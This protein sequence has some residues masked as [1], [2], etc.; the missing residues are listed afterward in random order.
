MVEKEPVDKK[1]AKEAEQEQEESFPAIPD[2][3]Y[4][5]LRVSRDA[6]EAQINSAFKR[7]I[8]EFHPDKFNKQSAEKQ[9][10]ANEWTRALNEARG[11]LGNKDK[12]ETYDKAHPDMAEEKKKE[13]EKKTSEARDE[14]V[15]T[16]GMT[17]PREKGAGGENNVGRSR[18]DGPDE[19]IYEMASAKQDKI[20]WFVFVDGFK[21]YINEKGPGRGTALNPFWR[22]QT[23]LLTPSEKFFE[24]TPSKIEEARQGFRDFTRSLLGR[25][26]DPAK[27]RKILE[28]YE[29]MVKE[30]K[31]E[32]VRELA[33]IKEAPINHPQKNLPDERLYKVMKKRYNRAGSFDE[34]E[35]KLIGIYDEKGRFT[36]KTRLY[37]LK[38]KR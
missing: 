1:E 2:D 33:A 6:T 19:T 26:E 7:R 4:E 8:M 25:N 30:G 12:R 27:E 10:A 35:F 13:D 23:D 16:Y 29:K 21:V 34:H 20:G 38:K 31:A 3:Y 22:K 9:E 37:R 5:R 36:G 24:K 11:T 28:E 14:V 17:A 18:E 15:K 32:F